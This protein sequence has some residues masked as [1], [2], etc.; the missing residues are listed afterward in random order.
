MAKAVLITLANMKSLEQ[1]YQMEEGDLE[2]TE[3]F[4]LTSDF[5]AE[6]N[7]YGVLD[8]ETLNKNFNKTGK[9]LYNGY[10]EVMHRE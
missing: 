4:Y 2:G 3:G 7:T 5:G 10:F 9:V 6:A 8:E 1:D